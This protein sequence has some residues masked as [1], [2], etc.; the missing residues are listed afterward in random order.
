V[1]GSVILRVLSESWLS[2]LTATDRITLMTSS[3]LVN[4]EWASIFTFVSHRDI[5]VP[6]TSYLIQKLHPILQ[7]QVK[8][9][10]D[11]RTLCRSISMS[12]EYAT[13]SYI[14]ALP[15]IA[16][17]VPTSISIPGC[18]DEPPMGHTLRAL[19]SSLAE[20]DCSL[21][22]LRT[23]SIEFVNIGLDDV[24]VNDRF[25]RFPGQV[26][27]LVFAF[28]HSPLVPTSHVETARANQMQHDFS[29]PTGLTARMDQTLHGTISPCFPSVR[30]LRILGGSEATIADAVSQCPVL[31]TLE[32]DIA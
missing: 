25:F 3:T 27:D 1:P 23:I 7:G 24:F 28:T 2:P 13:V 15:T 20:K 29:R 6:S 32:V 10:P 30:R 17:T 12:I 21:P 26:T 22:N 11:L 5:H 4:K 8:S 31:E 14:D 19:L 9:E 18:A 16:F